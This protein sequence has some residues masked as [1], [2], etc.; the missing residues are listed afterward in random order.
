VVRNAPFIIGNNPN[1]ISRSKGVLRPDVFKFPRTPW[2][3]KPLPKDC[4]RYALVPLDDPWWLRATTVAGHGAAIVLW[5]LHVHATGGGN[6]VAI[7]AAFMRYC[8]MS[9]FGPVSKLR[10]PPRVPPA[11][12][13]A[14]PVFRGR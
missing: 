9:D 8:G 10:F 6:E 3:K 13:T 2:K 5:W 14:F 11:A 4:V 7:T 12:R 1:F